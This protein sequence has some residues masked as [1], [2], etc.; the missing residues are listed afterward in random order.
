MLKIIVGILITYCVLSIIFYLFQDKFIFQSDPLSVEHHFSFVSEH[1]T[2]TPP[3]FDEYF[4]DTP[5]SARLNMLHFKT[6]CACKG[7]VVY[8]HGNA[9]NLQRW[10]HFAKDFTRLGYDV[11][12]MDYRSYGKSKGIPS[13]KALYQ[14]AQQVWDWAKDTF[15]YPRWVIYGRSLGSAVSTHL[16]QTAQPD[17]LGLET[18]FESINYTWSTAALP[19]KSKYQLSNKNHLAHITCR[20]F[21]F[22]GTSDWV[23]PLNSALK[24]KPLLTDKDAFIIIPKGGHK[25]LNTFPLYHQKLGELLE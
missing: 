12:M 22:H 24:L 20:K 6:P 5:D 17:I 25:N 9:D 23:V 14:D 4:L 21:I 8:F 11:L 19:F 10:G 3:Y 2:T 18:P 1:D 13:E 16:A 15:N 7:I